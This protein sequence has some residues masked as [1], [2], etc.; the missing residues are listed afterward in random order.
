[1]IERSDSTLIQNDSS[2]PLRFSAQWFIF[3]VFFLNHLIYQAQGKGLGDRGQ[4]LTLSFTH[5]I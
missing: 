4:S 1:V 5:H 3:H 2:L